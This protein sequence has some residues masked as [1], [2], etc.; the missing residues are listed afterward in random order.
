MRSGEQAV[1]LAPLGADGCELIV[2]KA[3]TPGKSVRDVLSLE[4]LRAMRHLSKP[5]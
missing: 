3:L 4:Q 2:P 1:E 5:R